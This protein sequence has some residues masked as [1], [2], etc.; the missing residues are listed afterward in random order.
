[1]Q[2][3][4]PAEV[5]VT[6][7]DPVFSYSRRHALWG[8]LLTILGT[9]ALSYLAWLKFPWLSYYLF[10]VVLFFIFIFRKM[11]A[12]RF[13][14]ANWLAR[15]TYDGMFIK[16]RSYLNAHFPDQEPTVVFI[17]YSEIRSARSIVEKQEVPDRDDS[18]QPT[19]TMKTQTLMDRRP[20]RTDFSRCPHPPHARAAYGNNLEE[21]RQLGSAQPRGTRNPS[22]R[23]GGIGR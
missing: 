20:W 10:S 1:M 16:F 9:G 17:P 22:A 13:Q 7:R 23:T 11:I 12:A 15:L 5:P 18:G 19:T 14:P 6:A 3:M 21:L 4:R 8:V 2:L